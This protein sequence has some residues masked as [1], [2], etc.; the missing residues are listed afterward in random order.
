MLPVRVDNEHLDDS[1]RM[2]YGEL[3]PR[4]EGLSMYG[5]ILKVNHWCHEK[6][7]YQPSDARTS[8][9]LATVRT[10]YGRCSEESTQLVAALQSVGILAHQIPPPL[11]TYRR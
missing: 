9:P 11:G 1:R 5:T 8:S 10:A 2:F 7:N 3:K 6:A 4:V